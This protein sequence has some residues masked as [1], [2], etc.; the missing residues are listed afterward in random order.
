MAVGQ[1]YLYRLSDGFIENKIEYD[2]EVDQFE[3]PEG[4]GMT[5]AVFVKGKWSACGIGWTYK[6]EKFTEPPRK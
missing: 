6:D 1:W 3:P 4:Y 2:D 5:P